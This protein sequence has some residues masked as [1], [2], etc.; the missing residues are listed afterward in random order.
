MAQIL[1]IIH[2]IHTNMSSSAM[3]ADY[4]A[5]SRLAYITQS[6]KIQVCFMLD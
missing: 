5:A 1:E 2:I 4:S 3:Q 6:N